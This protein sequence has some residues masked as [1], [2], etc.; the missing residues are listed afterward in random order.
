MTAAS[1]RLKSA[2]LDTKRPH[3]INLRHNGN[4]YTMSSCYQCRLHGNARAAAW[5]TLAVY[6]A[7]NV[8]E[9]RATP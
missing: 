1:L 2:N 5:C 7:R 9:Y 3:R 8:G 6:V 4:H